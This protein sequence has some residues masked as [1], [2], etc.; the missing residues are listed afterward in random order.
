MKIN[1]LSAALLAGALA[2]LLP[3]ASQAQQNIWTGS[4]GGWL[5]STWNQFAYPEPTYDAEAVIGSNTGSGSPVGVVNVS[6]DLSSY[7][8]PTVIL[9]DEPDA[10]DSTDGTLNITGTLNVVEEAFSSGDFYVGLDGG[11]GTL[12]VNSGTLSIANNLQSSSGASASAIN[13]S[14]TATLSASTGFLDRQLTLTGSNVDLSFSSNLILGLGGTHTWVIP[15]TGASTISVG[16][17][18]DLGGTL[19]VEFPDGTPSAGTTWNLVDAATVDDG[20]PIASGFSYVD[21]SSVTG[22]EAGQRF[23]TQTV[24]DAGSANGNYVQLVLEQHPVLIVNRDT[25]EIIIRNPGSATSIALD[26]Y[27]VTSS[28]G[29]LNAVNWNS[30]DPASG[31]LEANPSNTTLSELN[32]TGTGTFAGSTDYSL[33]QVFNAAPPTVFGEENEDIRFRYSKPDGGFIEGDVIYTGL[34]NNT[35]TLVVDP[36]TGETSIV[37]GTSFTVA[38]DN[39]NVFSDSGSLNTTDATWN[40]L[41]DQGTSNG[42]WYEVSPSANRLAE[43]LVDGSLTLAPDAVVSLGTAWNLAGEQDLS[44]TF[45]ILQDAGGDFNG[46]GVVNLADYTVWRNHLGATEDDTTLAGNGNGDSVVDSLD[47]LLW[48]QNFGNTVSTGEPGFITGKVLYESLSL[49]SLS[50]TSVPEPSCC[51]LA[52][53]SLTGLAMVV[54]HRAGH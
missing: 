41:E 52:L 33:G 50:A 36:S 28:L 18:A 19:K 17:N 31:W 27:A 25:N 40:S 32:P 22:L 44:F 49:G 29:A 6:S 26:S 43:L 35:L 7:P 2:V 10:G 54:R 42:N 5:D 37:N 38:I 4:T 12:N 3:S 15:S 13:L 34:P 46:D 16:G 11:L 45:A 14:G 48:K 39:Y 20:E 21:S 47:Y 8:A 9:G 51:L 24:S 30:L 53:L 1:L 23:A